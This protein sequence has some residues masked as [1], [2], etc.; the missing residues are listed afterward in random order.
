MYWLAEDIRPAVKL[1]EKLFGPAQTYGDLTT[2]HY[3]IMTREFGKLWTGD[4]NFNDDVVR[5]LEMLSV[6]LNKTIYLT[7]G[8]GVEDAYYTTTSKL[9][10]DTVDQL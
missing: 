4:L 10:D 9:R 2:Q 7:P 8:G 5:N 3:T 1:S 6:T